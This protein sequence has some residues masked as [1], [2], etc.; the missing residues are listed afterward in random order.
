MI[1]LA[2]FRDK[3]FFSDGMIALLN[4]KRS[5]KIEIIS[6]SLADLFYNLNL[7]DTDAIVVVHEDDDDE[8][9]PLIE[10][11]RTIKENTDLPVI[12]IQRSHDVKKAKEI[13]QVCGNV[14]LYKMTALTLTDCIK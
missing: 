5:L 8:A 13:V 12:F 9:V 6:D 7:K 2:C 1:R 14:Y 4:D 11:I 3:Y 10:I